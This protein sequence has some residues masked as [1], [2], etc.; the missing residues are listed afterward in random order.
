MGAHDANSA[1]QSLTTDILCLLMDHLAPDEQCRMSLANK[2]MRQHFVALLF[3]SGFKEALDRAL[4]A[5]DAVN[6]ALLSDTWQ[7]GI[8][9]R[10]QPVRKDSRRQDFDKLY[11]RRSYCT[12][13]KSVYRFTLV[14]R[15]KVQCPQK[16]GNIPCARLHCEGSA[17]ECT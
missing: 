2:A 16:A 9:V 13:F 6:R 8:A 12:K 11:D 7:W 4:V 3:V 10:R 15:D 1:G 5:R 17:T 14:M